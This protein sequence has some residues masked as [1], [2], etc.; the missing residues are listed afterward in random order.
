MER[1]SDYHF[2]LPE[3][4][5]AQ[6]P[7]P[8]RDASRLLVVRGDQREDRSFADLVELLPKSS[9][10]VVND[11]QVIPARLMARKPTGGAV[12]LVLVEPTGEGA[13][14]WRCIAKASKPIRQGVELQVLEGEEVVA[15]AEVTAARDVHGHVTA[16]FSIPALDVCTRAGAVPLPPYISREDGSKHEDRDRYQTVYA[17]EPGAVAAPTAGLHF[18][19]ELLHAIR[20]RGIEVAALT[21]HVG[22]GTFA[23]VRAENIDEHRL[24]DERYTI[25]E[26]TAELVRS[27]RP[28]VAVGTTSVRA[29]EGSAQKYG[30]VE[31]GPGRTDIFIR[32]G[33]EFQVVDHLVTNFHLPE[34]TLLMLVCAFAG[35]EPVLAAYRHAVAS[36]YRFYSYGDAMYLSRG[37]K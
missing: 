17:R 19:D 10:L 11:T 30:R 7:A 34:S 32:P 9:V 4:Q 28:V 21:L 18:T 13:L 27:G 1:T 20:G 23:P 12:E 25:P 37:P 14:E 31:A 5:I 26:R 24:H 29:L 2:D 35:Y 6:Q 22:P 15:S 16:R 8:T 3:Q 33:F 36:G